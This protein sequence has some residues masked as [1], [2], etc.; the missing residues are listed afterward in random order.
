VHRRRLVQLVLDR[1][2]GRLVAL[3]A[4]PGYGK[5]TLLAQ[6]A[7]A[8]V[9]PWLWCTCDE[10]MGDPRVLVQHVGAALTGRALPAPAP[11]A[12]VAELVGELCA[13]AQEELTGDVVL[14]LD[15]AGA[16]AGRPGGEALAQL[17]A[18]L[19]PNVHLAIASRSGLPFRAAR[20]RLAGHMAEIDERRLAFSAGES[21]ELLR[22]LGVPLGGEVLDLHRRAEGWPAGLRLLAEA[23]GDEPLPGSLCAYMDEELLRPLPPPARELLMQ[24]AVLE[25]V[26]GALAARVSGREDAGALL[27]RLAGAHLFLVREPDGMWRFHRLVHEFLLARLGERPAAVRAT[28]HLR[29]AAALRE[30]GD[31]W[32]AGGHYLRGGDLPAAAAALDRIAHGAVGA[33]RLD[34]LAGW[35]EQLPSELRAT[36]PGLAVAA[37]WVALRD[38]PPTAAAD[39]LAAAVDHLVDAGAHG[40]ALLAL[41]QLAATLE[42]AGRHA[43][44]LETARYHVERLDPRTPLL[45]ALRLRVQALAGYLGVDAGAPALA[46]A[47]GQGT[48]L[49]A[50]RAIAAA[51]FVERP[52]GAPSALGRLEAAIAALEADPAADALGWLP[53]ARVQR[54]GLLEEL[55]RHEEVLDECRLAGAA[56]AGAGLGGVIGPALEALRVGAL[57]A[58]ERWRECEAALARLGGDPL[59]GG[60]AGVE[61]RHLLT[62][63]RLCVQAGD[64]AA[65]RGWLEAAA[66]RLRRCESSYDACL[67]LCDLATT[68][69]ASGDAALAAALGREARELAARSGA[70]WARARTALVGALVSAERED[71]DVLLAEALALSAEN[72]LSALWRGRERRFAGVLLARALAR[73]LGPDGAAAQLALACGG[74]VEAECRQWLSE[75]APERAVASVPAAAAGPPERAAPVEAN[76]RRRAR[77]AGEDPAAAGVRAPLRLLTLGGFAV[78]LGD[79]PL[80]DGAFR[81]RKARTLLAVL[82][83][84]GPVHRDQLLEWL[85]PKLD[86]PRAAAALYTTLHTLRRTLEPGLA[87]ALESS[88][89]V[90]EGETYRLALAAG[91]SWDAEE[92]VNLAARALGRREPEDRLALLEAAE[93]RYTGPFLPDWPY[94]EWAQP[95]R[96]QIERAYEGVLEGI[97]E[98]LV[99]LGR[100]EEAI[101]RYERLLARDPDRESWHRG[102]MRAYADAGELALALRQYHICRSQLRESQ[103]TEPGPLTR[104]LH[105]AL[106][107]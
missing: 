80:G 59:A 47:G 17:V 61:H 42:L 60:E 100:P 64:G 16:L 43:A 9:R 90:K 31:C 101:P 104:A 27:E 83:S 7:A 45:A 35:L 33:D 107:G 23:E 68:A 25:R 99:A 105:R 62:R 66:T 14:A 98:A 18:G 88:L 106:L 84:A 74:A 63:A 29:A 87:R 8:D 52:R 95:R 54:A 10:R 77:G 86:P 30:R 82:V 20:L 48:A 56:A 40:R 12:S 55:G 53:W 76:G 93:R 4:A 41:V 75:L 71:A 85:W 22:T 5:T 89:V 94:E 78:A 28:L 51:V 3:V 103:G 50:Y 91:D 102:L 21:V 96:A 49:E 67:G 81:R 69:A 11:E 79:A 1:L 73:R 15:D 44:A 36:R 72:G 26:D 38:G 58:L 70:A 2:A 65:A 13:R 6:S 32:A 57:G 46:G 92:L 24:V 37:A 39:A 97:G 34:V 19:P